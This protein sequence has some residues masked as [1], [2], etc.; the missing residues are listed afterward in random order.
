V[1][2]MEGDTIVMTDIFKFE[3]TGV[4]EEG[5]VLGT[6]HPTGIRPMFSPRLEAVGYKLG[7]ELFSTRIGASSPAGQ[8]R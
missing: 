6:F 5:D 1:C 4:S 2:G 7:A 8:R 3:Q